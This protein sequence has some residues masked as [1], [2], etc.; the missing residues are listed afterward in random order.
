MTATPTNALE[1]DALREVA[2]IGAGHAASMLARLVGGVGVM[3]DVPRVVVGGAV[4]LKTLLG[5][6]GTKVVAVQLVI[7]G[8]LRGRLWWVLPQEDALRLGG[9]LLRRPAA[10]GFL[11]SDEHSA[12]AEAANVVASACLSAIGDLSRVPLLP[13]TPQLFEGDLAALPLSHDVSGPPPLVLESRFMSTDSPFF[14]G[15]LLLEF[16]GVSLAVLMEKLGLRGTV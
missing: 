9:R 2:N 14:G 16:D 5:G 1:Q 11:S 12:L 10:S 7:Q 8:G 4:A 15:Q 13:S 3:V 6:E